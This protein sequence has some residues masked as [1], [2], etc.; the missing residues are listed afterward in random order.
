VSVSTDPLFG[1]KVRDITGLYLAPPNKTLVLC[2][3][4][5]APRQA[6][7]R[8]QPLLPLRPRQLERRPYDYR[9]HGTTS[10]FTTLNVKTGKVIGQLHQRQRAR[11]CCKLFDTIRPDPSRVGCASDPRQ[12]Q[13]PQDSGDS[14]VAPEAPAVSCAFHADKRL[15]ASLVECWFALLTERQ[16]RRGL[17][18]SVHGL[19]A[20][21]RHYRTVTNPHPAPFHEKS[22]LDAL[23]GRAGEG[24]PEIRTVC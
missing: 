4:E 24:A 5:K 3:D 18:P 20:A 17:H 9:R 11:E 7:D 12:L 1:E 6:L 14:P 13:H 10:L 2:V 23:P 21:I 22:S 15:V 19:K 16:L 8:K